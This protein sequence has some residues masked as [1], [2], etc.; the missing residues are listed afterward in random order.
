[1][2][3]SATRS[4]VLI[5][6]RILAAIAGIALIGTVMYR[7]H[8]CRLVRLNSRPVSGKYAVARH[9]TGSFNPLEND[10]WVFVGRLYGENQMF[11]P[12][13]AGGG[14]SVG[15][16]AVTMI[17]R[18]A[19][20]AGFANGFHMCGIPKAEGLCAVCNASGG[21]FGFWRK[22]KESVW[23]QL[24]DFAIFQF[25]GTEATNVAAHVSPKIYVRLRQAIPPEAVGPKNILALLDARYAQP[26]TQQ[27]QD[28]L[29][30]DLNVSVLADLLFAMEQHK[31]DRKWWIRESQYDVRVERQPNLF[32]RILDPGLRDA[33]G[34]PTQKA[35]RSE[36]RTFGVDHTP[37]N[38]S[39]P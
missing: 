33:I 6:G 29:D 8:L 39:L 17:G 28:S 1:M 7:S 2:H 10:Q 34:S 22:S 13:Q 26:Q 32:P 3:G 4:P 35:I 9:E 25:L 38:S 14:K 21:Q 37:T 30:A 16:A 19:I 23:E 36:M 20:A 15:S 31:R 27:S 24:P 11:S 12:H 5:V 18:T